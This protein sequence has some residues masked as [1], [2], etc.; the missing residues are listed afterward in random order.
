M[1]HLFETGEGPWHEVLSDGA[2][3][4]TRDSFR[5]ATKEFVGRTG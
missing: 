4:L 3:V 2:I 1:E 5:E